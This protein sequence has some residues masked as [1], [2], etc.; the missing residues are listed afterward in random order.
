MRGHCIK[1]D[2]V[3][4]VWKISSPFPTV[5]WLF[6]FE[7]ELETCMVMVFNTTELLRYEK[8]HSR[9]LLVSAACV[10]TRSM[11]IFK[12]PATCL[13]PFEWQAC[14]LLFLAQPLKRKWSGRLFKHAHCYS[15]LSFKAQLKW[16]PILK[17]VA[18]PNFEHFWSHYKV[19]YFL[20]I[21]LFFATSHVPNLL[22]I[23]LWHCPLGTIN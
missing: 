6:E 2:G 11:V 14:S 16:P 10:Y 19:G 17:V 13:H 12:Y 23:K 4:E 21:T 15:S 5:P 3:V 18:L 9:H 22:I 7:L 1:Y 8:A 20:R